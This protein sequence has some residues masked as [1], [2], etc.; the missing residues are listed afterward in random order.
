MPGIAIWWLGA[1]VSNE[2]CICIFRMKKSLSDH[3][4]PCHLPDSFLHIDP[5][6]NQR[7]IFELK[8]QEMGRGGLPGD[9]FC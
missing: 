2:P 4:T 7:R 3:I 5:H 6:E 9:E 1:T 8:S